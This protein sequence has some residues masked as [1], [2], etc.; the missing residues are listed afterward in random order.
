MDEFQEKLNKYYTLKNNY[1]ENTTKL[2]ETIFDKTNLSKKEKRNL[3]LE[4]K[5]KCV[6]CNRDVGT[7]FEVTKKDLIR[8]LTA[9]CGSTADPCP[10]HLELNIGYYLLYN[11][12]LKNAEQKI[13]DLKLQIILLKNNLLYHYGNKTH[14]MSEFNRIK[15]ELT[16]EI[17]LYE[18]TLS[19]CNQ[20]L[21]LEEKEKIHT[22]LLHDISEAIELFQ[23][24]CKEYDLNPSATLLKE[25]IDIYVEQIIPL[26]EEKNKNNFHLI[27][28]KYNIHNLEM[29]IETPEIIHWVEGM[30]IKKKEKK[31]KK[32]KPEKEKKVKTVKIITD[33]QL[34]KPKRTLK[35]KIGTIILEGE[36]GKGLKEID[37]EEEKEEM[38]EITDL[39]NI[40]QER[41]SIRFNE[42][43]NQEI[44]DGIVTYPSDYFEGNDDDDEDEEQEPLKFGDFIDNLE[45]E[46]I[47]T[48]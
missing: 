28:T 45:A 1:I 8:T 23:N 9:K 26:I 3:F 7:L 21:N 4:K 43:N 36:E 22:T 35:K 19:Q 47:K 44:Y 46:E 12:D 29:I 31:E 34:V 14:I 24:K 13:N 15:D 41:K 48:E 10:L 40:E 38:E 27:Q 20:F 18:F 16:S 32:E 2:K 6:N 30:P 33:E 37:L 25:S 42:D 39:D 5:P 17:D 11:E